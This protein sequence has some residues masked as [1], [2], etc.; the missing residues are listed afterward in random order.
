MIERR[1]VAIDVFANTGIDN[2]TF[3]TVVIEPGPSLLSLRCGT[4]KRS[5]IQLIFSLAILNLGSSFDV[6]RAARWISVSQ[7]HL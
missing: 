6:H 7:V 3:I 5:C 2:C 1:C 4:T